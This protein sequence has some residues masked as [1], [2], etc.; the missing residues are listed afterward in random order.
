VT[1]SSIGCSR[2]S[3][4]HADQSGAATLPDAIVG[5]EGTGSSADDPA[6]RSVLPG[7]GPSLVRSA[8]SSHQRRGRCANDRERR[9]AADQVGAEPDLDRDTPRSGVPMASLR[10]GRQPPT[11]AAPRR[12]LRRSRAGQMRRAPGRPQEDRRGAELDP[13]GVR[14]DP[15]RDEDSRQAADE[16]IVIIRPLCAGIGPSASST[17]GSTATSTADDVADRT[18]A[19]SHLRGRAPRSRFPPGRPTR[20]AGSRCRTPWGLSPMCR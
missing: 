15:D 18:E 7:T 8:V 1:R 4:P 9:R 12:R 6:R 17:T 10:P 3:R 20:R 2:R 14:V 5:A 13:R 11:A 19:A 16:V